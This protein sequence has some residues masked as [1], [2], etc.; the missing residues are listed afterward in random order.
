MAKIH[1]DDNYSNLSPDLLLT[2][3][4]SDAGLTGAQVKQT[5]FNWRNRSNS[6]AKNSLTQSV[7]NSLT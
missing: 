7:T 1:E 3:L 2:K 6:C 4:A 5:L